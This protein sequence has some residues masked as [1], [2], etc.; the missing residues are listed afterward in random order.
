MRTVIRTLANYSAPGY[1][2][3]QIERREGGVHIFGF[4]NA[5]G[6]GSDGRAHTLSTDWRH[7]FDPAA[8]WILRSCPRVQ[9][10]LGDHSYDFS[11]IQ[12]RDLRFVLYS[13]ASI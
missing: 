4:I 11:R 2:D 9:C 5:D 8:L 1:A 3:I 6:S 12:M 10:T 7:G 13:S